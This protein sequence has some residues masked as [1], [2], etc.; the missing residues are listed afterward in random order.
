M[1]HN[2]DRI[3]SYGIQVTEYEPLHFEYSHLDFVEPK[4]KGISLK[5]D[6]YTTYNYDS[7]TILSFLFNRLI[8]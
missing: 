1:Y 3:A 6:P 8:A 5:N 7:I 4:K 2:T